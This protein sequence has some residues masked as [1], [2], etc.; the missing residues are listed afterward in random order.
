MPGPLL[1]EK[2]MQFEK[3]FYGVPDGEIYPIQYQA[4]DVCPP[5]LEDSATAL[6]AFDTAADEAAKAAA[7]AAAPAGRAKK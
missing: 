2:K 6:G 4:G 7:E 3:P 5:E 1:L